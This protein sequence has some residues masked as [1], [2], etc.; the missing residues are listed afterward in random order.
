MMTAPTAPIRSVDDLR[1]RRAVVLGLARSGVA[2][3]RFLADA[4]A[5]VAAYD[6]RPAA[7]LAD[8]VAALGAR[9]VRLALGVDEADAVA[10]LAHADLLVTSPSVSSRFP[11]TDPWLREALAA[12]EARG[13]RGRERGGAVPAP[14]PGA[15]PGRDRDEGQDD[16]LLARGRHARPRGRP[17]R[18]G[19]E[20]R[21]AARRASRPTS[22]PTS[23]R[24]SSSRSSSCRRSRAAPTWRSTRTSARTIS[25]GTGRSRRTA[26][27]RRDSPS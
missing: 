26:R 22:G 24:S 7:E 21:H 23:G 15:D 2:A 9:P 27:S 10:L 4:G 25:T 16:D 13:R 11:T 14:D 1:G 19:R 12:A 20:H 8:A 6:R 17:A 3:S 5:V 18:A